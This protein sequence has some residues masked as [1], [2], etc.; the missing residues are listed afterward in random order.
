MISLE[1]TS[2]AI[3]QN[4]KA[5]IEELEKEC[6]RLRKEVEETKR[7]SDAALVVGDHFRKGFWEA[8]DRITLLEGLIREM[9][10]SLE[11]ARHRL[12]YSRIADETFNSMKETPVDTALTKATKV[13]EAK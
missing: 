8:R 11:W 12:D 5:R 6:E 13:M 10:R 1:N 7:G 9:M 2:D 3:R 4:Q